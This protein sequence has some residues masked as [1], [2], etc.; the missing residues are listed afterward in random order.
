MSPSH[1]SL[2]ICLRP[3]ATRFR[4]WSTFSTTQVTFWPFC[5]T[6]DGF[7]TFRTQ[8]MSLTCSRPSIPSSISMNAP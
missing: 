5:T 2:A 4:S 7:D 6:S 3:R 8:L 1:G